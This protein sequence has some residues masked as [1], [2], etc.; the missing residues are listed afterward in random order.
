[1][2]NPTMDLKI[3][4]K[5]PP[6]LRCISFKMNLNFDGSIGS[7]EKVQE[8]SKGNRELEKWAN[9]IVGYLREKRA[10]ERYDRKKC[11]RHLG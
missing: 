1:M 4:K 6:I 10:A 7:K 9:R 8:G 5:V 3:R 2:N 11:A